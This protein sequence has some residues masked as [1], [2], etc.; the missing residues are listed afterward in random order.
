MKEP[1]FYVCPPLVPRLMAPDNLTGRCQLC[2]E[3]VQFRPG[4]PERAE[5]NHGS[6][7]TII[8]M[9]CAVRELPTH[10]TAQ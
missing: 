6:V 3:Q 4:G 5:K 7:V 1:A 10:P 2:Q 8:C 9:R